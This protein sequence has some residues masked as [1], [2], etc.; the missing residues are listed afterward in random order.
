MFIRSNV[1]TLKT[2]ITISFCRIN[3]WFICKIRHLTPKKSIRDFGLFVTGSFYHSDLSPLAAVSKRDLSPPDPNVPGWHPLTHISLAQCHPLPAGSSPIFPTGREP[4]GSPHL[5]AYSTRTWTPVQCASPNLVLLTF[6]FKINTIFSA[7]QVPSVGY[8]CLP[9]TP[10]FLHKNDLFT[11]RLLQPKAKT[12]IL[13]TLISLGCWAA[14]LPTN[15]WLCN[16]LY[17][18]LYISGVSNS[19]CL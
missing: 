10:A 15:L 18:R 17:G 16:R 1:Q 4:R 6:R 9:L 7:I 5:C 14:G 8:L 13:P 3:I 11:L 2:I 12:R 19:L